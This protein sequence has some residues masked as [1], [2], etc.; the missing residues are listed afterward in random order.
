MGMPRRYYR[1][2]H[3]PSGRLYDN[4]LADLRHR[5]EIARARDRPP[6]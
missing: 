6:G 2:R 3:Y 5:L 4:V 1:Q